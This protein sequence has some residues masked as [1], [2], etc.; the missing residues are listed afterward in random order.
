MVRPRWPKVK[1]CPNCG[2]RPTRFNGL[3]DDDGREIGPFSVE[4]NALLPPYFDYTHCNIVFGR[5]PEEAAAA[6]NAM[7]VQPPTLRDATRQSDR[8]KTRPEMI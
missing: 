7:P 6:W 5:T 2:N 8:E 3:T 1:P 4:C